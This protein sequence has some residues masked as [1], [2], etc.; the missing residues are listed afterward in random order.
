MFYTLAVNDVIVDVIVFNK[1]AKSANN[2]NNY[3]LTLE[4]YYML[5]YFLRLKTKKLYGGSAGFCLQR[6]GALQGEKNF[7]TI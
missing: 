6:W 4:Y 2:N 1:A 7:K 3:L 5:I